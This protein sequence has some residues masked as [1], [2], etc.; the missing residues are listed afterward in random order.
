MGHVAITSTKPAQLHGY[1]GTVFD[2][3]LTDYIDENI[4]GM[5]FKIRFLRVNERH[6]SV[7]IAAVQPL[8]RSTRSERGCSTQRPGRRSR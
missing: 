4:S 8:C 3:R 5:K 6:H 1:F 2:A 7:A